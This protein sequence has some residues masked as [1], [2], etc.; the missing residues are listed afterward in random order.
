MFNVELWEP[1]SSSLYRIQANRSLISVHGSTITV[2][3]ERVKVTPGL[4]QWLVS[5]N[6]MLF[7][8]IFHSP[9]W[10][11]CPHLTSKNCYP[12]M[13]PEGKDSEIFGGQ[14]QWL[15]P[16]YNG[17]CNLDFGV[18][19]SGQCWEPCEAM[20]GQCAENTLLLHTCIDGR[21]ELFS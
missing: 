12:T 18:C 11:I 16:S 14:H 2:A 1:C 8:L 4:P 5:S 15:P 21:R 13:C 7:S 17:N 19:P 20:Q 10:V 9:K 3:W 6:D